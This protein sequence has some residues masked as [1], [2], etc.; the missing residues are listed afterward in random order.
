MVGVLNATFNNISDIAWRSL[1][2]LKETRVPRE[3]HRPVASNWQTWSHNVYRVHLDWALIAKVV[4]NP[5]TVDHD[6]DVR[7]IT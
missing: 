3:N 5:T 1:S 4:V 7:S 6:H 2:L